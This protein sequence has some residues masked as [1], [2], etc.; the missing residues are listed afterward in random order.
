MEVREGEKMAKARGLLAGKRRRAVLL[1]ASMGMLAFLVSSALAVHD[2]GIFQLDG[3]ASSATQ[4]IGPKAKDDWDKVCHQVVEPKGPGTKCGISEN[5]SGANAVA[6]AAEPGLE[7]TVFTG[8]GS[9]DPKDINEWLWS[10]GS[11]N[12][13]DNLLHSFAARYS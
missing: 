3:D 10:E 12:D 7:E 5:T 4:P 2:T 13:K 9:K 6:W 1:L 11:V 8:G